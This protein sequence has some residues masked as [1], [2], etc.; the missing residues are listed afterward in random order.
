MERIRQ[1]QQPGP[2]SGDEHAQGSHRLQTGAPGGGPTSSVIYQQ[3]PA[4]QVERQ[5]NGRVLSGIEFH[6]QARIQ[7]RTRH[8]GE[9]SGRLLNPPRNRSRRTRRTQFLADFRRYRHRRIHRGQ[10]L[11]VAHE[12]Q[13]VQG[14]SVG[15]YGCLRHFSAM[16]ASASTSSRLIGNITPWDLRKPSIS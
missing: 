12:D 2:R 11:D 7:P 3:L 14:R 16:S 13:V 1:V 4:R 8:H 10:D 5:T 6:L 15:N 9:P